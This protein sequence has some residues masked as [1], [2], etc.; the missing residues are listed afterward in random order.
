MRFREFRLTEAAENVV[1]IGD[2][3]ATGI[4]KAGGVSAEYTN[5]GKDTT[6]ILQNLVTPF[7]KSG[8]AKGSVVILSSGAANSSKVEL[9]DGTPFQKENFGPISTQI[10][11]LK[12]A[13]ATVLLVGTASGKSKPQNPTQYTRGKRWT[14]DYTGANNQLAS[15]A[16][17]SGAKFLGPLE[18][19]DPRIA[20]GDGIHPYN[21]YKKLFQAGAS[22]PV[23]LGNKDAVPGAPKSKDK[24]KV[25]IGGISGFDQTGKPIVKAKDDVTKGTNQS[26]SPTAFKVET[27]KG[28]RGPEIADAQ[29][30]LVAFGYELPKHGVDGIMGPETS[31]A[32][33]KFQADNQISTTGVLDDATVEKLNSKP[34]LLA[35]LKKSTTADVKTPDYSKGAADLDSLS[36]DEKMM[37]A[38]ASA[39]KFLGKSIT[40]K[41]WNYLIRATTAEASNNSREQAYVMGVILNRTRSGRWGD[42]IASVLMAPMQFQAVTG[43]KFEPGPSSNFTRGPAKPQLNSILTGA[44]DILPGVDKS[45]MYFTAANLAAY[46]PGTNP[47]F[48]DTLL[49]RGGEQIGQTIFS[50]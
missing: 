43:T 48:R 1:V 42:S 45:L 22:T 44:I 2:S 28:R 31:G 40:D 24:D 47:K 32:I 17:S 20:A 21:G 13:G 10:K 39:E 11:M 41:D 16:S 23:P 5:P 14:I 18:E 12:D 25:D 8:K 7:I 35:K 50:S 15:I 27:P 49:G 6:F 26:A 3:I 37:D 19:F 46:G 38:R 4:A 9:E 33:K 34:E 36:N 29:K 30:A